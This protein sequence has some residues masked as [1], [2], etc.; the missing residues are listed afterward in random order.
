MAEAINCRWP[1]F[2]PRKIL[3][4][5]CTIGNNTLP[6]LD[7]F[8]EA[9]LHAID[10]AA[11]CLRYGH[12]R[13]QALGKKVHFHQMNA[14]Q[15]KFADSSFD[16]VV[17]CILFHEVSG[18]A[19]QRVMSECHRV[20]RPGGLALHLEGPRTADLDPYHAFYYYWDGRFNNEPCLEEWGKAD[21]R[22]TAEAAGFDPGSYVELAVPDYYSAPRTRFVAAATSGEGIKKRSAGHWG[23]E[24]LSLPL[25]AMWKR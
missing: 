2:K 22:K 9:E 12:A 18:A 24:D 1:D 20:L 17:S 7:V 8:P 6:Y 16:L 5:G 25:Y 19:L 14:E 10:V 23:E 15:M 21:L 4:V 11:P 13:A 3:D